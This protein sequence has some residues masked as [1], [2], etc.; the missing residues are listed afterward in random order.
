M[1]VSDSELSYSFFTHQKV[2]KLNELH[3]T[4]GSL[5]FEL[6]WGWVHHDYA[7]KRGA[8]VSF[9]QQI[10][11][12]LCWVTNHISDVTLGKNT[13]KYY[14]A[15]PNMHCHNPSHKRTT[16]LDFT[17]VYYFEFWFPLALKMGKG[18]FE[19]TQGLLILGCLHKL[20]HL[21]IPVLYFLTHLFY[22][23]YFLITLLSKE[24]I[25][26]NIWTLFT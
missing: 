10:L 21:N 15:P 26:T 6:L 8:L 22:Q 1:R 16:Q 14:F 17:P 5:W 12:F 9:S 18:C 13:K 3:F 2:L 4:L 20:L 7:F 25:S 24:I 19:Q 11:G 23:C